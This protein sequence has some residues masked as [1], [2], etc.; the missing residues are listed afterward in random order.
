MRRSKSMEYSLNFDA[1]N[2]TVKTETVDQQ[3]I[4]YRAFENIVYVKNPVDLMYHTMNI[5]VPEAYYAGKAVGKFTLETA[6]IFMPNGVGGYMPGS[7]EVPGVHRWHRTMNATFFALAKGYVVAA[8]AIRGRG[9]KSEQGLFIGVAPACIV[10]YK[11]A[12]RY[13]RYNQKTI[14]GDVRKIISN[15][16][17]AGG[18]LSA[19]LGATGNSIDYEPYLQEIGAAEERDDIFAASCYCPI[20]NLVHADMAYEWMFHGINDFH[21]MDFSIEEG[22][23]KLTPIDGVMTEDQVKL[24]DLLKPLFPDYL[25]GLKLKD[26]KGEELSL[27]ISGEGSFKDYVK[28][29]VINSAQTALEKGVDLSELPWLTIKDGKVSDLDFNQ[30]IKFATRMKA[31]PAFDSI[32]MN[33]PENE[34]FGS[35]DTQYQHFTEFGWSHSVKQGAIA[36]QEVINLMNPMNYIGNK[37]STI[38]KYYRIRHGVVDRDTSLAIPVIIATKLMNEGISVDFALPWGMRHDGDYDLVELFEWI[39]KITG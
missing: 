12:V 32:L 21:T 33:T 4:T 23:P 8:P 30:Y 3:T 31:T 37:N 15:G 26:S 28:T 29:F 24:S 22:E 18:A 36:A 19:L 39:E 6:P 2:F 1:T 38:A 7:S 11:A 20:T 17:S 35:S 10:D 14:P 5:Y 9:L 25:N 34:L 16:T 13:L 27:N